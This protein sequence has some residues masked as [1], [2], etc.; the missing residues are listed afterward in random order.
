[1]NLKFIYL[2]SFF[3]TAFLVIVN[4]SSLYSRSLGINNDN[5]VCSSTVEFEGLDC[6]I[7]EC[8]ISNVIAE[9]HECDSDGNFLVDIDFD[10]E[11]AGSMGFTI[12]GNGTNYGTFEYGQ[13]FY[14]IGPLAGDGETIYEFIVTDVENGDCSAFTGF[15]APIDCPVICSI[16]DIVVD[17]GSCN[18]DG[19]YSLTL[20][21]EHENTTNDF[22]DVHFGEIFI[23]FFAYADLP[24]LIESFPTNGGPND[25]ITISDNDNP[26]CSATHEFAALDCPVAECE[27]GELN[28]TV[29][30]CNENG[31]F[32]VSINFEFAN[33]GDEG[34]RVQGNGNNYGNFEYANLPIVIDGLNG[35]GETNYE[36]VV[37]D[38]QIE[39]CAS[40]IGIGTVDCGG[41]CSIFDIVVDLGSC[42]DDDTYSLTLNF[43]HE[44]TTNDFFDVHFGEIFIGFFAYADLPI[45]I[46]SFPTNGGPNDHITISDNDNPECSSTHE[47]AALDCPV[48][49]CE[50][51]ELNVTVLDCN[52]NGNFAVSINFEFANVGDEGFRVQ[53][54]GNNYG[55]FSYADLPIVIDGLVGDNDTNY[56][57]VVIDNQIEGCSLGIGIGEVDCGV[58]GDCNISNVFA[59]AGECNGDGNFFVDIEFDVEFGSE[60]GF[61]IVGNGTNYGNFQYGQ[62]FYTIGPLVGDGTTIYEFVVRD[63]Q[64]ESCSGVFVFEE[65]ID[66]GGGGECGFTEISVQVGECNDNGTYPLTLNFEPSNVTNSFFDLHFG[67]ISLGFFAYADLPITIEAFPTDGGDF[68]SITISDND[69]PD[70]SVTFEFEAPNCEVADCEIG[71]LN[72]TVLDCNDN[73][74]F[75]VSINFEFANVGDEGFRVQGNGNNYGNF[76]YADLPIVIDGLNGN[77]ETNY[78]FAVID[79]AIEGCSTAIDIGIVNCET[80][81]CEIANVIAEAHECNENGEFL[82]DIAF[83]VENPT[84]QTFTIV[85]NGNNYGTFEYGETF[86]TIGPLVGDGTTIYEFIVTD[87]ENDDCSAFTGLDPINCDPPSCNIFDI[88]LTTSDCAEDG[89]FNLSVNFEFENVSEAG[90]ELL[91]NGDSLGEFGYNDLPLTIAS[92]D[93]NAVELYNIEVLDLVFE[94]CQAMEMLVSPDCP[95]LLC[96]AD[97]GTMPTEMVMV[98]DEDA[99]LI[100]AEGTVLE[101]EDVLVYILHTSPTETLGDIIEIFFAPQVDNVNLS[102]NTNTTYYFSAVAGP[103]GDT[104]DNF[105]DLGSDCTKIA[106]G[107]P[108]VFLQPI[109]FT[110]EEDCDLETGILTVGASISGGMPSFD[111]LATYTVNARELTE[112]Q[113]GLNEAFTFSGSFNGETY[114][115]NA[116]DE[117]DCATTFTSEVVDCL[118]DAISSPIP[119]TFSL[120]TLSPNPVSNWLNLQITATTPQDIT[121]RIYDVAGRTLVNE[122]QSVKVG[123]N[124]FDLDA[125]AYPTGVYLLYLQNSEGIV[126]ERFVVD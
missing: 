43:E 37:I 105:P 76:S 75:E 93:A 89:T 30:D 42:N 116:T 113:V 97:A 59:E 62:N 98:C 7:I 68:D 103:E 92:L 87:T 94:T 67:E 50:I 41:D 72:V 119:I 48:A 39:G 34:F 1:M 109:T 100:A 20:N 38:N 81:N 73:G 21:F 80:A 88:E 71:E 36:F 60:Q 33:V 123:K 47:F 54:N 9:A 70:C 99:A 13:T 95:V 118:L 35:D 77:G 96:T 5:S 61:T 15:E 22:F 120:E 17:L 111:E 122:L 112:Q 106:V 84:A 31:N 91:I 64:M 86:Y 51:G 45:L 19:T 52:E 44:N 58:T 63:I 115:I 3:L 124:G 117:N 53:G 29:L 46:E 23:G 65:P 69:N 2:T 14:T 78:E 49:E 114:F 104:D 101:N 4:Q 90:F 28:V 82:V 10:I 26:E 126:V 66:C 27:I 40:D 24:I 16:F 125:S 32:A 6:T 57:F 108:V 56:E 83:E 102:A 25:H 11:D 8:V 107:T 85:G 18:D 79:N 74:N 12:V 55:N 110:V 121:L